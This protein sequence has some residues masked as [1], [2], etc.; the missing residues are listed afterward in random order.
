MC[1]C[2]YVKW[3]GFSSCVFICLCVCVCV[4]IY[5]KVCVFKNGFVRVFVLVCI[6]VFW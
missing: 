4:C 1:L 5:L 3:F 6:F 2:V